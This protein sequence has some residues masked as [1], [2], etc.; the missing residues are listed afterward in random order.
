[1]RLDA[2]RPLN[3]RR[4]TWHTIWDTSGLWKDA[5][6]AAFDEPISTETRR[7]D[8]DDAE[9]S[10]KARHRERPSDVGSLG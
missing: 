3:L 7:I 4:R 8:S 5:V 9:F 2:Y 6:V 1:M 10:L